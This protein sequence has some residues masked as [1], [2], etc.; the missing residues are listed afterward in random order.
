M[1]G[2]GTSQ[3]ILALQVGLRDFEIE[4][5]HCGAAVPE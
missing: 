1:A 2:M 4:Q 3:M 5:S